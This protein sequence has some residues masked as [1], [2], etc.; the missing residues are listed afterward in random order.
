M[1]WRIL[2]KS[3]AAIK[4]AGRFTLFTIVRITSWE[5]SLL[6]SAV[7]Q[8]TNGYDFLQVRNYQCRSIKEL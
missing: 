5:N 3:R 1:T 2:I 6:T 8:I 4:L 7:P